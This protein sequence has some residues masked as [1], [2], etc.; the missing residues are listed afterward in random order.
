MKL[1]RGY[2]LLATIVVLGAIAA[3]V[4]IAHT[5]APSSDGAVNSGA[6]APVRTA[7][8]SA[9]AALERPP[10]GGNPLW[11]LPLKQLSNTRERPIFSPSRRP[12]PPD[13]PTYVAPVAVRTPQKPKEPE[14][15]SITLLG[16]ILGTSESIGIFLDPATR[17][18]L[19]LRLGEDH[20][21]WALRG[22]KTREV[23]LVKDR[24]RVVLELPPPGDQA[25][26][27]LTPPAAPRPSPP[28]RRQQRR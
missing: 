11:A 10:A 3:Y 24:E 18:I 20:E 27:D 9:D 1:R 5:T 19:R 16:T 6:T 28:P 22:V 7:A 4:G 14:R 8:P 15:P 12:P 26:S 2:R 23:T 21:G 17:D 25:P 13:T